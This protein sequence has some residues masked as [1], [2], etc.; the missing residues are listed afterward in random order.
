MSSKVRP[1]SRVFAFALVLLAA[2]SGAQAA[3]IREGRL[4]ADQQ[5]NISA[6]MTGERSQRVKEMH[7][8]VGDRVKKGDL[9]AQLD[10]EQLEADRLIAERALEE[11]RALVEVA[12]SAVAR[13][14]LNYDRRAG[15]KNSPSFN[16]AAF[17]DADVALRAA[18]SRLANATSTAN[19]REAEMARIDVEIGLAE[20]KAPYDGIVL[21]VATNVGAAVTQ[22]APDLL[23]LLDLSKVEIAVEISP[24][25][26]ERLNPGQKIAYTLADGK[27]RT[28]EFRTVMPQL[29]KQDPALVARLKVDS[30]ELPVSVN[31]Q[32]AVE[33]HLG[34]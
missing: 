18:K 29:D 27:M 3:D 28:A 34:Q 10:T 12:Q 16:R 23:K 25:D 5:G 11:A 26:A 17:E 19:R 2:S 21:D 33:V 7:V 31:H 4:I 22:K 32:D 1:R 30:A 15:L 14:Q 9:L 24:P 8:R 6:Q 13:E 20:I